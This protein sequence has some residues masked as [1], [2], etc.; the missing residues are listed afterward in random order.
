MLIL[1]PTNG[2]NVRT[3]TRDMQH[4]QL[5]SIIDGL[6]PMDLHL[7]IPKFE[8]EY[9]IDLVQFLRPVSFYYNCFEIFTNKSFSSKYKKFSELRPI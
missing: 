5:N 4:A 9:Q 6:K 3:L 8:I 2:N 7:E 1:L